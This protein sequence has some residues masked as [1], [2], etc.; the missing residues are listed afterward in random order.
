MELDYAAEML[1]NWEWI[2]AWLGM[3]ESQQ[4]GSLEVFSCAQTA[5]SFMY[6]ISHPE[7]PDP[8]CTQRRHLLRS[9]RNLVD[10]RGIDVLSSKFLSTWFSPEVSSAQGSM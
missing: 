1:L 7:Y 2:Q 3:Y 6:I 10:V 4:L 5:M 9:D 8:V